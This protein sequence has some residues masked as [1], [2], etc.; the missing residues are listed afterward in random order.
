[1][2]GWTEFVLACVVFMATHA[3]PAQPRLK[4]ALVARLGSRGY[5]IAFGT[6]AVVLLFWLIYAAA[7]AP[8]VALWPQ[9]GWMRW[10]LNIVMPVVIVLSSYAIAA[11]NPFAFEGRS[12][13]YDPAHPGIV[14]LTR[15][16]LLWALVLWAGAHLIANGDLAHAILFGGFLVFSLTGMRAMETRLARRWG[17]PEF[18]RLA[19]QT[20]LLPFAALISGRWR[21]AGWPSPWRLAIAL[22]AW[23][24]LWH[25]HAPVIG[26]S[27]SP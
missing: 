21:P 24:G 7:D 23:M 3:I 10:L 1:M 8:H 5:G 14:G 6:L 9:A 17:Q 16:P 26:V 12:T 25:L 13:G 19:S 22:L 11:P 2:G 20:A 27:P 4:A 18:D 15:Q